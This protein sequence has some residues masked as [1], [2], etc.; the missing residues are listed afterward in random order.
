MKK[1]KRDPRTRILSV[2]AE[3]PL[4]S[5][6]TGSRKRQIIP[7]IFLRLYWNKRIAVPSLLIY[8]NYC[9]KGSNQ[10]K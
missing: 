1:S 5:L 7:S 9:T 10:Q 2:S 4:P 8:Q 3:S 6:F